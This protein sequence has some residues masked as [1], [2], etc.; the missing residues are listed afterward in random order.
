MD[1]FRCVEAG[2]ERGALFAEG[3]LDSAFHQRGGA[4]RSNTG[5]GAGMPHDDRPPAFQWFPR[6]FAAKMRTLGI[7]D[8]TELAYRRALDASWDSG[9]FGCGT[10]AEW[11][12]WGRASEGSLKAAL[13]T[14][15]EAETQAQPDGTLV[16]F[17]MMLHRHEQITRRLDAIHYGSEGGRKSRRRNRSKGA[18]TP[19]TGTPKAAQP[20]ASAFA[21]AS[22]PASAEVEP[23]PPR[24]TPAAPKGAVFVRPTLAEVQAYCA[25]RAASGRRPVD[26]QAWFDHYTANGWRVGRSPMKDWR[27]AVRTW[28]RSEYGNGTAQLTGDAAADAWLRKHQEAGS[29]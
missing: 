16:Q 11:L 20:P 24:A 4:L 14:L 13:G 27:A 8:A 26:P 18:H 17:R 22:A 1:R 25:E 29:A 7:D 2:S 23:I 3:C 5:K 19:P 6:D 28:E 10:L 21:S 9:N 12:R 15:L